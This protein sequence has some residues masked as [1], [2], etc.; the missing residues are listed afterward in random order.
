MK[1]LAAAIAILVVLSACAGKSAPELQLYLLRSDTTNEFNESDPISNIGIGSLRVAAYIDQ[2]GLVLANADG[3]VTT[4][5]HHQWAEP[6]RDSL[7]T[8][9]ANDIAHAIG[10]PVRARS[11][12]ETNWKQFTSRLIE[13]NVE[14]LHGT[15]DGSAR[16]VVTWAIVDPGKREVISEHEFN[17]TQP[18]AGDGYTELVKAEKKLMLQLAQQ[19][20]A[21]LKD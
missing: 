10:Q 5:Q 19:I 20:A 18:L 12:S 15:A 1:V 4:A 17:A 16:L 9:L 6:L 2:P 8:L 21:A 11:Y 13:V 7:R 14:Q 3:T